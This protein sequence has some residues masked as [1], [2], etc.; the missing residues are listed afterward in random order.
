MAPWLPPRSARGRTRTST[1]PW[2]GSEAAA[3]GWCEAEGLKHRRSNRGALAQAQGST[4]PQRNRFA[5]TTT[6]P[7]P[8]GHTATSRHLWHRA[9][10][11]RH[12]EWRL[13]SRTHTAGRSLVDRAGD[14]RRI[15]HN[16]SA[17]FLPSASG[18]S[19]ADRAQSELALDCS[20]RPRTRNTRARSPRMLLR[21]RGR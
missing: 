3:T 1:G 18:A 10:Q 12:Q 11:P 7:E 2:S 14:V 8:W 4:R 16:N 6:G 9:P 13:S 20:G 21:G 19:G 15:C 5:A 17:P